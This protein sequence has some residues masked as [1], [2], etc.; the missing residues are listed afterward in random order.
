[1]YIFVYRY[2]Y[3]QVHVYMCE[4]GGQRSIWI[5]VSDTVHCID[6]R[7]G[8]KLTLEL[9]IQLDWLFTETQ[10]FFPFFFISLESGWPAWNIMP[11]TFTWVHVTAHR[12]SCLYKKYFTKWEPSLSSPQNLNFRYLENKFLAWRHIEIV[13]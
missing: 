4:W 5:F 11:W 1:M 9:L 2:I 13:G 6:F 7:Q 12:S 10:W 8:P 3:L